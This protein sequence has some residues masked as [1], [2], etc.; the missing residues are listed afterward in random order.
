MQ[1]GTADTDAAEGADGYFAMTMV[2]A[3]NGQ[4]AFGLGEHG[5]AEDFAAHEGI[6]EVPG[7][8]VRSF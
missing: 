3:T 4:T 7:G 8:G 2:V 5:L 6:G 1:V